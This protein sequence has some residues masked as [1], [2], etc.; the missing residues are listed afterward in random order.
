[1][2]LVGTPMRQGRSDGA[3]QMSPEEEQSWLTSLA[4]NTGTAIEQLGLAL[5]TPGAI[6]RGVLAG[7]PLSGFNWDYD[8]RTSG[9]ELLQSYGLLRE[10]ANPYLKAGAGFVAEVAT[11]PFS[12]VS[13]PMQSL[14]K[15][16][17][18]ARAANILDL[19][20][21]VA[22]NKMGRAATG[23]MTG[24]AADAALENLL[25]R[26]LA[27]TA[28]NYAVRPLVGPR[29]ARTQTTL[30]EVVQAA[31]DPQSAMQDVLAYLQKKGIDYDAV[32]DE[33][34]GGAFGIG[35]GSPLATFTP[36]GSEKVLDAM[37]ALGQ[38]I[39][40][41]YPARLAS[42]AFDNRVA[43]QIDAGDQM[44]AIRQS[45]ALE[46]ARSAGRRAAAYHADTV[47]SIPISSRAKSLLGA[48]SLL[49][50]Q[51]ND[52]LTRMFENKPTATDRA[53]AQ[54][55]P[56]LDRAMASWDRIRRSNIDQAKSLG[57]DIAELQDPRFGVQYSPRS[58]TELDFGE[59]GTG[60]GRSQFQAGVMEDMSRDPNLFTPGGTVD[61]REA[62]KLPIVR[63]W[64]KAG[65]SSPQSVAQVGSEIANYINQKHGYAAIDQNQGEAIARVMYRMN[66]DL[67]SEV[68]LFA[69][70]P[71]N[72][73][74]R[75]IISQ[76]SARAN[77]KYVYDSLTESAVPMRANMIPGSGFK[78][79]VTAANEIAGRVGL[80]TGSNGLDPDVQRNIVERLAQK[81]G[82]RPDQ[83]DI[84]Q[85]AIPEKVYAR[86][87]RIQDFYSAPR[88]QQEVSG[89][90][91][92]ITQAWKSF[93]LAFPARHVRDWYSNIASVWLETGSPTAT[94]NGFSIARGVL[95][96]DIESVLP[97]IA[98]LPRYK[99]L[100]NL[101]AVRQ[102]VKGDVAAS[103]ILTGL[104][105]ADALTAKRSGEL[106]RVLPGVNPVSRLGSLSA[107]VPDGSRG[108]LE[109]LYD[110][111]RVRGLTDKFET[112]NALLNW[113]QKLTDANDSI[114]RLGG[115]FALMSQGVNPTQA[116]ERM[117]AA[118]VNYESLTTLERGLLR[119]IFP[120][121]SYNS[122]IGK[123]VVQSMMNNPGGGYAQLV[124]GVN[125]LQQSNDDTYVPQ[126]L[127]Q[128]ISFRIPDELL[129]AMGISQTP[130][131]TTF[132]TSFALPGLETLSY[133]NPRSV[134]GTIKNLAAQTNPFLRGTAE[135]AFDTD[136][137]TGRSLADS[138]PAVNKIYR[139][140]TGGELSNTAKVVGQN[141]PGIQRI[142]GIGGTLLDDRYPLSR[143]IPKTLLNSIA[144]F[145]VDD[146]NERWM[147]DD[148]ARQAEQRLG[149]LKED[150][151]MPF[152][153]KEKL[154]A[155]DPETQRVAEF[156]ALL[157]A[158][159]RKAA[160]EA[161]KQQRPQAP[162]PLSAL[163]AQ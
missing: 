15:A 41:S 82:V 126:R 134:Q 111:T 49:S 85:V 25:P 44:A 149:S 36:P 97:Q 136:L 107:F 63:E 66:K 125:T 131:N 13:L 76:E 80:K 9:E 102:Q 28:D 140:L 122:R 155:A 31:K 14:T 160:Q 11:D 142:A 6:T 70:H 110:Q 89:M 121:Y 74:A 154:A 94:T 118:L 72:E 73:Q 105:Q 10:D 22:Q 88:V 71:V 139:A 128:Q 53:L 18:A 84:S 67:P 56:G 161:K 127:R 50:E 1:M 46:E 96:G 43:G 145:K 124:R 61:L 99:A 95:S 92:G 33:R 51:G 77:A 116:A 23:T 35:F 62:S 120:W 117:Q 26:G 38:K 60:F 78:N 109:M 57:M 138:D 2:V 150:F 42:A 132:L 68:P 52:F 79:I 93:L 103:G 130:G 141:F 163:Y 3:P 58:G 147:W 137:F 158:R 159:K 16:G 162:N 40:W 59:Y 129:Q 157:Q 152:L 146:A 119:K 55:L 156:W 153:D 151:V 29:L 101:D 39:A 47:A 65:Q 4:R 12:L 104:A 8:K 135:L 7:D 32:K 112:R 45:N 148:A 17:K 75:V 91:D 143:T 87:S 5:D 64:A 114:A 24:R 37:D 19:A 144:G 54:E 48:D 100:G 113:S 83:I 108:P 86:L 90:F 133:L 30:D 106:S 20:P 81:M 21:V 98:E 115:W 123:Y 34:L 27:K 69:G